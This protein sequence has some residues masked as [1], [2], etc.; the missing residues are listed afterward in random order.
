MVYQSG[1]ILETNCIITVHISPGAR[2]NQIIGIMTDGVVKIKISAP[3]VEGKA[4][5]GLVKY[6]S[7]VLSVPV[8]K[9]NIVRG[10][11][12]HNKQVRISGISL[13]DVYIRL[14]LATEGKLFSEIHIS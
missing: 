8:S 11:K 7:T 9:I 6:L 2:K 1:K 14:K 3:P 4:N 10:E 12:S 5:I 13:D